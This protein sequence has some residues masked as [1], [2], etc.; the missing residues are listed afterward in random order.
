MENPALKKMF[1]LKTKQLRSSNPPRKMYQR[2]PAQFCDM[3]SHIGFHVEYA[4]PDGMMMMMMNTSIYS[5]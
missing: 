4:P 1:D 2:I 5:I 3:V